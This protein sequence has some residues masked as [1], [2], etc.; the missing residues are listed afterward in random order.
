MNLLTTFARKPDFLAG[1]NKPAHPFQTQLL[2]F[3]HTLQ[4]PPLKMSSGCF[5]G[6][7][8][9]LESEFLLPFYEITLHLVFVDLLQVIASEFVVRLSGL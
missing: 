7:Q 5:C 9:D 1:L 6:L 2:C 8:H 3:V 4:A